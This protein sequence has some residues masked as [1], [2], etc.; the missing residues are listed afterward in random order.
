MVGLGKL[1][2][3]LAAVLAEAGHGVLGIERNPATRRAVAARRAP[4]HEPGLDG[5]LEEVGSGLTVSS[6]M[7]SA[8]GTDATFLVVATSSRGDGRF[9][10]EDL[11]GA[12][13]ELGAAL[14]ESNRPHLVV[15]VSTVNP[16]DMAGQV[17]PALEEASGRPVGPALRVCYNPEFLALGD[18]LNGYRRP[19][20]VLIGQSDDAAG[21]ALERILRPML[22]SRPVI[23]RAAFIQAELAKLSVNAY[24]GLKISF[25]NHL[26]LLCQ[27]LGGADVDE[28]TRIV[29][30][31]PRVGHAYL[32]GGL[33]FGGPCLPRDQRALA[34]V[35]KRVGSS[36]PQTASN[37]EVNDCVDAAL[38]LW[39]CR[40]AARGERVA[41][42]GLAFKPGTSVTEESPGVRL[43]LALAHRGRRIS[44]YDPQADRIPGPGGRSGVRRARTLAA[45]VRGARVVV[46]AT[47]W[48]GLLQGCSIHARPLS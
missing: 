9:G 48:P 47:P 36:S 39:V 38:L 15:V 27:N 41:V 29:G 13:R 44:A 28:V 32:R 40:L 11:M 42:L 6:S 19:A 3:P 46:V 25:A 34:A 31:D 37:L 8:A 24:L 17:V 23:H 7:A 4:W 2:L 14:R 26:A 33:A 30:S 43:A 22:Q 21:T 20:F 1:G 16:G 45:A 10:L 12:V 5:L 18:A 35:A